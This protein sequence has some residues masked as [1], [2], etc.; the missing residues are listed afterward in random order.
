MS[1]FTTRNGLVV[2]CADQSCICNA[3]ITTV[4]RGALDAQA[5]ERWFAELDDA[6]QEY[7]NLYAAFVSAP[8]SE[9]DALEA[10][11]HEAKREVIERF[12]KGIAGGA[13]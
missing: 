9:R 8:K 6:M 13:L 12:G 11:V 7:L 10:K 3:R 4:T 5:E 2:D 1:T